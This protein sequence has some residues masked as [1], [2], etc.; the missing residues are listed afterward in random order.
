MITNYPVL[1]RL[2]VALLDTLV[3][4][5]SFIAAV[6]VRNAALEIHRFGAVVDWSDYW[7][8]LIIIIL[9]WRSLLGYQEAYVSQR[10]TSLKSDIL[11]VIKTVFF[12]TLIVLTIAFMIKSNVPRTLVGFFAVLNLVLLSLGKVLLYQF[13][14]YL[15]N[16][17]KNI[18]RV[19]VL[20]AGDVAKI[21]IDSVEKYPDWGIKILGLI[22]KND[23]NVGEERFGYKVVGHTADFRE[24]LHYNPIDELVI[25]LPAKYIGQ[26]QQVMAICDE[27]GVSVRIVSPFFRNLIAKAKTDMVHGLPIIKFSSVERND[28]EAAL[29]RTMDIIG[30]LVL[31][32]L[33]S[34]VFL[35]I[36]IFIK[37]GSTGPVFYRWKV[38]SLNKRPLTSYKFRTMVENADDLKEELIL[39]NEMSGHAFK[40]KNDPRITRVGMWLRKFSLD[41][42]PQLWSV[43]KG[44]LSLV[45][46]RPPLQTEVE[47][48]EGWHRRKLS[49]KP[50]MTCLWQVSGR[51]EIND[52]DEWMRLDMKYIDEWSLWLDFK[53]LFKTAWVV[54]KGTGR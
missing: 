38:L 41:E 53:I 17:G 31:L 12:G 21:F 7:V 54:L 39:N 28:F 50:G 25:A 42:L 16:Q 23:V 5:V 1:T 10:F 8:I 22:C 29:K 6:Y 11:I 2:G 19:L 30:S 43:L 15:R 35:V 27:E 4:I 40:M 37:L 20:G 36:A 52:F 14:Q 24:L 13:I 3:T 47:K 46:P 33:L 49:V 34:P 26:M 32:I 9:T 18:K 44:D 51:N 45:G 48:F